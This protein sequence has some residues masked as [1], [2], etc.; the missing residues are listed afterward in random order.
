MRA[1]PNGAG[2]AASPAPAGVCGR[3]NGRSDGLFD[4]WQDVAHR[5]PVV[6]REIDFDPGI[7]PGA[8]G[9]E[10]AVPREMPEGPLVP[11][12]GVPTGPPAV[13]DGNPQ[14][15]PLS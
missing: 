7:V 6:L 8:N 2:R 14:A 1:A 5:A 10:G 12:T 4:D 15:E 9:V 3:P 11:V 13:D